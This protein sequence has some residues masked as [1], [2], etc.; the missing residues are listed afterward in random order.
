MPTI[1]ALKKS[2]VPVWK[3]VLAVLAA[4]ML[5]I[6]IAWLRSPAPT[7]VGAF[8]GARPE[9]KKDADISFDFSVPMRHRSVERAFRISPTISGTFRWQGNRLTFVP[10]SSLEKGTTFAVTIGRGARTRFFKGLAADFVQEFSVRNDPEI[11]ALAPVDGATIRPA[12]TLTV[13]FDRPLRELTGS[14]EVPAFLTFLP[15]LKGE[16]HWQGTSGFEFVPTEGWAPATSYEV[17]LSGPVTFLDGTQLM[18][19]DAWHF[20]TPNVSVEFASADRKLDPKAALRLRFNYPVSPESVRSSL[21]VHERSVPGFG[22]PGEPSEPVELPKSGMLAFSDPED[23]NTV[24]LRRAGGFRLGMAYDVSLPSG[25]TGGLGSNGLQEPYASSFTMDE[26]GFRILGSCPSLEDGMETDGA[27]LIGLNN[28]VDRETLRAS[29]TVTPEPRNLEISPYG[30]A[31]NCEQAGWPE[32]I[33]LTARWKPST[34]YTI[35]IKPAFA[36]HYGQTIG[37]ARVFRVKTKPYR[38]SIDVSGFGDVGVLAA[39]APR[40]FQVRT[41]NVDD[42]LTAT[43]CEASPQEYVRRRWSECKPLGEKTYATK[44]SLND[45]RVLNI[46]LDEVAGKTVLPGLYSLRLRLPD[47]SRFRDLLTSAPQFLAVADTVLTLKRDNAGKLLVWANDARTGETSAQ[48]PVNI[49]DI[50]GESVSKISEGKTGADGLL[51]VETPRGTAKDFAAIATDGRRF[52]IGLVSW[53][54]GISPWNFNLQPSYLSASD[55]KYIG[56]IHTDRLIYRPDQIVYFK[57][58]VRKD[59]DAALTLPEERDIN[60]SVADANGTQVASRSLPLSEYGTFNGSFQLEPSM[61]LGTY[62]VTAS[63]RGH[64][65]V[66]TFDVRE[67]RKPDFKIALDVPSAP[68]VSGDPVRLPLHVEYYYGTPLS[69][70]RVE[71]TVT[72][73]PSFFQPRYGEWYSF[74]ESGDAYCYWHCRT[75]EE[76]EMVKTGSGLLDASGNFSIDI[77]VSLGDYR[78]GATYS[79]AATV[80]DV[81]GRAVSANA[82]FDA[83]KG[84]FDVGIRPDP[85]QPWGASEPAFDLLVLGMNG[86]PEP[87][88]DG[89]VRF[90]KRTWSSVKKAGSFGEALYE[91]TSVDT[92]VA[93]AGFSTDGDGKARAAFIPK[94]D[95]EYLAVAKAVDSRGRS[96]TASVSRWVSRGRGASVRVSDDHL[97]TIIQNKASYQIGDVASLEVQSPY[98]AT[99]ALV[100]VERDHIRSWRV[101]DIDSAQRAIEIP[102]T[103]DMAPNVYVSVVAVQA[104]G[105]AL[106]DF[107]IGYADVQVDT[108][109]KA[110]S[111]EIFPDK[112]AYKPGDEVTLTITAKRSDGSPAVAETSIA[113]VDERVVALLGTVDRDIL[114]RF[115][116]PRQIG[117]ATAQTITRLVKKLFVGTQGG[118]GGKGE[119]GGGPAIRGNFL[120][121]AYWKADVVTGTDGRAVVTFK[122][123]DN[124]T[125][126][127]ILAIGTTKDTVVGSALANIVTRRD[128]MAEPLLPRIV[129]NG[130][131][132]TFGATVSNATDANKR[133]RV[134]MTVEGAEAEG[135]AERQLALDP[136][137]RTAVTWKARVPMSSTSVTVTVS[138]E[139]GGLSDGFVMKIP[140]FGSSVPETV[141]ASN[142]FGRSATEKISIPEGVLPD[143]GSLDL[144]VSSGVGSGLEGGFAYLLGYEYGCTEQTASALVA[145]TTY[146]RLA[147]A[148]L[149]ASN[150]ALADRARMKAAEA[151]KRLSSQQRPNGSWSLWPNSE[152]EY[153]FLTAYAY[154]SLSMAEQSGYQV[155]AHVMERAGA[156]LKNYLAN[157]VSAD[158]AGLSANERAQVLLSLA[159][160]DSA[161]LS[162]YAQSLYEERTALSIYGKAFLAMALAKIDGSFA[163][164]SKLLG[165]MKSQLVYIDPS[166]AYASSNEG[167]DAYFMSSDARTTG[168]YLQALMRIAP[169]DDD[170]DRLM[171]YLMGKKQDGHWSDTQSTALSLAGLLA[172]AERHPIDSAPF[173]VR[174]SLDGAPAAT[175]NFDQGD[176]S[177]A[178][179][180]RYPLSDLSKAS[181]HVFDLRKDS[182]KRYFYDLSMT[183]LPQTDKIKPFD[184]GFTVLSGIYALSDVSHRHPLAQAKQGETLRVRMKVIVPKERQYVALE[185]HLP[186]GLEAIDTGLRTSPQDV[187]DRT[188]NCAP[189]WSGKEVCL[190]EWEQAWWWENVWKHIEQRDDRVFLFSDELRPGVYE[191]EFLASAVTPGEFNL[192]P[193]RAYEFYKP[194]ANGHS[195]GKRFTVF[196]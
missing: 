71:Y 21:I 184:N 43:L 30:W 9:I 105:A 131:L 75:Q 132:V 32:R 108:A 192:P 24:I 174:V 2:V 85:D 34:E 167:Y 41:L 118:G 161:N 44:T 36:D 181:E 104:G 116:F 86:K 49:Y 87:G 53:S 96:V 39:S 55:E 170:A 73:R 169:K 23:P 136:H 3:P 7:V 159:D 162:G 145:S 119:G 127:Q 155:D 94:D 69:G 90:F 163:R 125:S 143:S 194:Q 6:G 106:P 191:Y 120:D 52:G 92:L 180:V 1:S 42:P 20:S 31:P 35:A 61:P 148:K 74:T 72:R 193:A 156:Y 57:G 10:S 111:M 62:Q 178:Q 150:Q 88:V 168:L 157:P 48:L 78:S 68:V 60:L 81:N 122:L 63:I 114:G 76:V 70:A 65:I 46:D 179:S 188:K 123:P 93:E 186:A 185:Y 126:W 102:I 137:A 38:P 124:L 175:L 134:K 29:I 28:P 177:S 100:T 98:A 79:V 183:Y 129:R 18:P 56:F 4:L 33:A 165:E 99:K 109:S 130:D 139:G 151:I 196:R 47:K 12:Q 107:R 146:E 5:L 173:D 172:Y 51:A 27:F 58:E 115:W 112:R 54:E 171:R 89:R 11:S 91:W 64:A 13:L 182:E 133:L 103:E 160:H 80:T 17:K 77:P 138:A 142:L 190:E 14:L 144:R 121:T 59:V 195:E 40:V 45:Y 67:Y 176:L 152:R 135:E 113:V 140:V 15:R 26:V 154:W 110:L 97:M 166:T 158:R 147:K 95:G 37:K 25:F 83:K 8:D 187:G 141:Q 84:S 50:Y 128:V 16:Y 164:A 153:P 101:V 66:G 149:V 19:E 22:Q 82:S 117:V 189:D